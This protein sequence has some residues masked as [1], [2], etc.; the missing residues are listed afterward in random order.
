MFFH[1]EVPAVGSGW[2]G[3]TIRKEGHKWAHLTETG[4]Q[5]NFRLPLEK[6]QEMRKQSERRLML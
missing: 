2:R 5:T 4:T 6:W 1:D 3:V